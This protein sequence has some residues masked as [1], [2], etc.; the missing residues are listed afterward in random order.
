MAQ[1]WIRRLACRFP[2]CFSS[3]KCQQKRNQELKSI[4]DPQNEIGRRHFYFHLLLVL[5]HMKNFKLSEETEDVFCL[6]PSSTPASQQQQTKGG[7]G[8]FV[9]A[10]G[11][12]PCKARGAAFGQVQRRKRRSSRRLHRAWGVTIVHLELHGAQTHCHRK[13]LSETSECLQQTERHGQE[14]EDRRVRK[15]EVERSR[16]ASRRTLILIHL[17]TPRKHLISR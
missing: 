11:A 12:E 8:R 15:S 13:R 14:E 6:Q 7:T 17:Y 16:H 4:P 9:N 3:Y 5:Q 2:Y 1:R 10:T